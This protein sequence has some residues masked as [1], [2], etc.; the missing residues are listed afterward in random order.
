MYEEFEIG[1]QVRFKH[2]VYDEFTVVGYLLDD[3]DNPLK[4]YVFLKSNTNGVRSKDAIHT[5][6]LELVP[7]KPAMPEYTGA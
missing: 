2:H 5:G 7:T 4:F 6:D 3:D 1:Q